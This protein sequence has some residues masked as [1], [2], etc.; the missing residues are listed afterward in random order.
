MQTNEVKNAIIHYHRSANGAL[1]E[2]ERIPT[3][4]SASPTPVKTTVAATTEAA[5]G[6]SVNERS[7]FRITEVPPFR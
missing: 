2:E 4:G 3:G 1:A 7:D 5:T 6:I